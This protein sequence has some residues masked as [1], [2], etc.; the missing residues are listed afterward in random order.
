MPFYRSLYLPF[1][2][3][4]REYGGRSVREEEEDAVADRRGRKGYLEAL[5]RREGGE[6]QEVEDVDSDES[7]VSS[8]EDDAEGL[9]ETRRTRKRKGK[10]KAVQEDVEM[11]AED[12]EVEELWALCEDPV[13][14]LGA[15]DPEDEEYERQ[16]AAEEGLD[17]KDI[18]AA[19]G[20]ETD[21]WDR[22]LDAGEVLPV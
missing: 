16:M 14:P 20:F 21:V 2:Q 18:S 19:K 8:D 17:A 12:D 22:T 11:V 5:E 4:P 1:I 13:L 9:A 6:D 15:D 7:E 10:G 3:L